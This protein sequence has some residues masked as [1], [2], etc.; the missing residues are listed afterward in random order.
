MTPSFLLIRLEGTGTLFDIVRSIWQRPFYETENC[1]AD[2]KHAMKGSIYWRGENKLFWQPK[3][4][5]LVYC[6]RF[7]KKEGKKTTLN[8]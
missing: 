6:Q 1:A 2:R 3:R 8:F 4:L 5:G 7:L